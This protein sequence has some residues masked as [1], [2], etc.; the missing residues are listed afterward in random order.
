VDATIFRRFPAEDNAVIALS[1]VIVRS[2][3]R[4]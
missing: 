3:P 1:P 2:V 4:G